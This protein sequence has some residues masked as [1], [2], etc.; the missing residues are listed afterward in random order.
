MDC[1]HVLIFHVDVIAWFYKHDITCFLTAMTDAK[2]DKVC[3]YYT[4]HRCIHYKRHQICLLDGFVYPN[5]LISYILAFVI[6][7][8]Q[9]DDW[10]HTTAYKAY[11]YC[12]SGTWVLIWRQWCPTRETHD[13]IATAWRH[14]FT[15]VD[16]RQQLPSEA[17]PYNDNRL[18]IAWAFYRIL[19]IGSSACAGNAGNVFLPPTFK[20]TVS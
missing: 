6:S 17:F 19:K 8:L 4:L 7:R 9:C 10:K 14:I 15:L 5:P 11:I 3:M 2:Q 18:F 13:A 20:E 12:V 1:C 16:T